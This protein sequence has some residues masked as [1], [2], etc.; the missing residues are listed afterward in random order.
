MTLVA[1]IFDCLA[2]WLNEVNSS[3]SIELFFPKRSIILERAVQ[4][5]CASGESKVQSSAM[6]FASTLLEAIVQQEGANREALAQCLSFVSQVATSR[7]GVQI[8]AKSRARDYFGD[9]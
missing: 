5:A 6:S 3:A 8:R 7:R 1:L 9:S 2:I 4:I